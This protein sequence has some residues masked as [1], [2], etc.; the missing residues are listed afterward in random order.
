[1]NPVASYVVPPSSVPR[2]R[3]SRRQFL[4]NTARAAAAAVAL[5]HL[6]TNSKGAEKNPIVGEGSHR[7]EVIHNWPQLPS[8]YT[9]QITHNVAVDRN[10]L[11][12]VIHEGREDMKNHPAIFVFDNDGKFVRAFGSQFQG[13]GH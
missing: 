12:Y 1:M 3:Q 5:P 11:V 4:N 8:E 6:I 13:G 10:G 9:W 2:A 7:Y